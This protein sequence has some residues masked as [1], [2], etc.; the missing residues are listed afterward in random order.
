M[1][2]WGA[3]G[4]PQCLLDAG[5]EEW[6]RLQQL[7][8]VPLGQAPGSQDLVPQRLL[9]PQAASHL[10]QVPL[11]CHGC[12]AGSV[13]LSLLGH[14]DPRY[15]FISKNLCLPSSLYPETACP[16]KQNTVQ[17]QMLE[18]DFLTSQAGM[19]AALVP[20]IM[21]PV[22]TCLPSQYRVTHTANGFFPRT[23]EAC[24]GQILLL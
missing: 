24:G 9:H 18:T 3:A 10:I 4:L 22:P 15:F 14:L 17:R 2:G 23:S 20:A 8:H 19:L 7:V 11:Q 5:F 21:S 16:L 1:R 6:D 13:G 12:L